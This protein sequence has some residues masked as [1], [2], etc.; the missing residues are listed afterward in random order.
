MPPYSPPGSSAVT[1]FEPVAEWADPWRHPAYYQGVTLRRIVA[2]LIDIVIVMLVAGM[3]WVATGILGVLTFGLLLPLHA[4]AVALVPLL[5]HTLLIAG[6]RS[7]TLGMRAV[8]IRVMSI[9][10]DSIL[11]GGRPALFQAMIQ[12]VA[13]YGSVAMTGSLILLVTLFNPRRRTLHDFLA[14]TV[15]VNDPRR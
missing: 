9:A 10:P 2:Y 15:V 6:P 12:T 5:Y 8:G 4:L 1:T 11:R 14:G 7:A 13:F 3:V